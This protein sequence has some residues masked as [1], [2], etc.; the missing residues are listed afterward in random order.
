MLGDNS[1]SIKPQIV[2]LLYPNLK[3]YFIIFFGRILILV[4][5]INN[6]LNI[7]TRINYCKSV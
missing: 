3:K 4:S 7:Y 6:T 5:C 2:L 1:D